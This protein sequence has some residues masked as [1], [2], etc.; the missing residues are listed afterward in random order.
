VK[1][2]DAGIVPTMIQAALQAKVEIRP[3]RRNI[4]VL[5]VP[6]EISRS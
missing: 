4:S 6:A 5:E 1:R 3:L 2:P